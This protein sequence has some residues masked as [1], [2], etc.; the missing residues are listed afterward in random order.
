[1]HVR[2]DEMVKTKADVEKL[3]ICNGDYIAIDPK[4]TI[5]DSGLLNH[6]F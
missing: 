6:A 1:M 2:I 3:G 4:T 5:T